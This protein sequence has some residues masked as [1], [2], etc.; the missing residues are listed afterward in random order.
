MISSLSSLGQLSKKA[1]APPTPTTPTINFDNLTANA[2]WSTKLRVT[3]YSGACL[4]LRRSSDNGITDFYADTNG[5]LGTGVGATGT[6][7]SSWKGAAATTY[8]VTWYDQSGKSNNMIQNTT[9]NQPIYSDI[10]G[11]I[12]NGSTTFLQGSGYSTTLNTQ[13][14]TIISSA[15]NFNTG[16]FGSIISSRHNNVSSVYPLSGYS[17]YKIDANT[18]YFQFGKDNIA[19]WGDFITNVA[20]TTGIRYILAFNRNQSPNILS[21]SI[22][23]T[24]TSA[25][26]DSSVSSLGYVASTSNAT[27]IGAGSPESFAQYF[28]NGYIN[29]LFYFGKSLSTTEQTSVLNIL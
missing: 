11:V 18:W 25:V 15:T 27:R 3:S 1:A 4:R 26:S 24:S 28:F 29:D 6:S 13:I 7:Y 17:L 9:G 5:S 20:A 14:F 16:S 12:F 8:L 2:V 23:N 21:S 10:S 22:K 19:T